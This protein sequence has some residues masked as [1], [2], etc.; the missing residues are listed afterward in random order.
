M[1]PELRFGIETAAYDAVGKATRRSLVSLLGGSPRALAL[2]ATIAADTP[3]RAVQEASLALAQGFETLKLKVGM[4]S[5]ADVALV[6]AVRVAVGEAVRLRL[7]ANGAW[8]VDE[9][10]ASLARLAPY[11]LEY[12][13]QPTTAV[14]D[15]R[16]VH[17]ISPVALAADES[18]SSE[19]DA[20]TLVAAGAAGIWVVKAARIGSLRTCLRI[21]EVARS[22]GVRVV[23][24]SSLETG[25]GLAAGAHLASVIGTPALA[26][27]LATGML[28]E[29]DLLV[30][31]P[32]H[33]GGVMKAPTGPG[34]GVALDLEALRRYAM[35]EGG[36]GA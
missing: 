26:H 20:H 35:F 12:V 16:A 13:E 29:S 10:V 18:L 1:V 33:A 15:L 6:S 36:T 22:A 5:D 25:V 23:V 21:A 19:E 32:A 27:G 9:A 28:L 8:S 11:D 31:G 30:G 14:E 4:G 17:A 2:N 24:T 3:G 34:L 7:D